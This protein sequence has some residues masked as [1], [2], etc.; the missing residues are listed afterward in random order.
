MLWTTRGR[1]GTFFI[2]LELRARL[3]TARRRTPAKPRNNERHATNCR[4]L[5]V[6]AD[7]QEMHHGAG[8]FV[9][10]HTLK[11]AT[12]ERS[13]AANRVSCPIDTLVCFVPSVVSSVMRRIPC[14]PLVT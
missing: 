2:G 9:G 10:R 12:D 13:S 8:P 7:S 1:S 11:P 6:H 4:H 5:T 3:G 14:M